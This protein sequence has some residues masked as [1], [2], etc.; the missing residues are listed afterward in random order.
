MHLYRLAYTDTLMCQTVHVAVNFLL[1]TIIKS[2]QIKY[3]PLN[4]VIH[5]NIWLFK[6]VSLCKKRVFLVLNF[7]WL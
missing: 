5:F 3:S 7:W 6:T 2:K 4:N 1:V